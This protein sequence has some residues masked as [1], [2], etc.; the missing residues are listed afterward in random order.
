[1]HYRSRSIDEAK[2]MA[3]DAF[4]LHIQGM[5]ADGEKIQPLRKLD[6]VLAQPDYSDAVAILIVGVAEPKPHT[7]RVDV[8]PSLKTCSTKSIASPKSGA[9]HAHRFWFMPPK[10]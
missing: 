2:E 6:D 10:R 7:V 1:M 4:A 5:A 3:Q 8:P 9:C